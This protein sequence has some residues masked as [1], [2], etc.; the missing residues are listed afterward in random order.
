MCLSN[1]P[2]Y[3][4][5]PGSHGPHVA[6]NCNISSPSSKQE[7]FLSLCRVNSSREWILNSMGD[8]LMPV[9]APD[10]GPIFLKEILQQ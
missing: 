3:F 8:L 6:F 7:L 4:L 1:V 10:F 2:F 9:H 5:W